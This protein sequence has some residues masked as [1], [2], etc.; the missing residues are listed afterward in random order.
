MALAGA[1]RAP[2][3]EP[4]AAPVVASSR[5]SRRGRGPASR[6]RSPRPSPPRS[7]SSRLRARGPRRRARPVLEEPRSRRRR[8]R[9]R[10]SRCRPSSRSSRRRVRAHDLCPRGAARRATMF[11]VPVFETR[12]GD[13]GRRAGRDSVPRRRRRPRRRGCCPPATS[14][15]GPP[16]MSATLWG[17]PVAR[18]APTRSTTPRSGPRSDAVAARPSRS[19]RRCS[20]RARVEVEAPAVEAPSSPAA[21]SPVEAATRSA[22]AEEPRSPPRPCRGAVRRGVRGRRRRRRSSRR[23]WPAPPA[24]PRRRCRS[25]RRRSCRRCRCSPRCPG[26]GRPRSSAGAAARPVPPVARRAPP[27]RPLRAPTARQRRARPP[28]VRP[29]DDATTARAGRSP[30]ATVTRLPVAPLMAREPRRCRRLFDAVDDDEPAAEV[31]TAAPAVAEAGRRRAGPP[32]APAVARVAGAPW[33]PARRWASRRACSA[34]RSPTTSR[35]RGTYAALTRALGL[36]LPKAPE[37][38]T[39][40]GEVLFLVGPGVETLRAARRWPPRCGSTPTACS[41]PPGATWPA[42]RPRAA[43]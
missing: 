16:P 6:R 10:R 29:D 25:T 7:P 41:G 35:T 24:T 36:R 40:A 19:S 30:L 26:P 31:P 2:V 32:V 8:S 28:S 34:P 37:L 42:S 43:G 14:M 1:V 15:W 11:E 38:P 13:A 5:P 39:G 3:A 4:I 23:C 12:R 9:R 21:R 17:E 27:R 20:S 22:V 18:S 33:P